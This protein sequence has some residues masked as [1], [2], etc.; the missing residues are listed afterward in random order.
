VRLWRLVDP[1]AGNTREVVYR[2]DDLAVQEFADDAVRPGH[3]YRYAVQ[4]LGEHG[5]IVGRSRVETVRIPATPPAVEAI[6]LECE[7]AVGAEFV[8]CRWTAPTVPRAATVALWRSVDGQGRQLVASFPADGETAYR[9]PVPPGASRLVYAVIVTNADGR[10][11]GRSRPEMVAI[12]SDR[13]TPDVRPV[14]PQ[15]VDTRPDM[16]TTGV[17]ERSP[18]E[19][20]GP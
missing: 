13:S 18:G 7:L 16:V 14:A 3:T 17:G 20:G 11:V 6:E 10:I 1:G 4:L 5:R 8:G 9:D 12:P 2:S 15:P 19:R